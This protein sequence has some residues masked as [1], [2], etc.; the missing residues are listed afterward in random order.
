M[1]A[2]GGCG[3][4]GRAGGLPVDNSGGPLRHS[5]EDHSPK[6]VTQIQTDEHAANKSGNQILWRNSVHVRQG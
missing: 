1:I 3:S 5:A 6:T 4:R 2:V